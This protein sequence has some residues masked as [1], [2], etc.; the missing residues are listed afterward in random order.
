[1]C[2]ESRCYSRLWFRRRRGL[3]KLPVAENPFIRAN[4]LTSHLTPHVGSRRTL[5][6][7]QIALGGRCRLNCPR[8]RVRVGQWRLSGL[9]PLKVLGMLADFDARGIRRSK[10]TVGGGWLRFLFSHANIRGCTMP[11]ALAVRP[12]AVNVVRPALTPGSIPARI[13]PGSSTA[14]P[15]TVL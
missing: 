7:R 15:V 10:Q 1:M 2:S 13:R 14:P 11:D 4:R 9:L 3:R 12:F 8:C 6:W 5:R